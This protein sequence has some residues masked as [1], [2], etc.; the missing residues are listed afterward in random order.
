MD[1]RGFITALAALP[2][3]GLVGLG[4]MKR[5]MPPLTAAAMYQLMKDA[6]IY[7]TGVGRLDWKCQ[8]R[9]EVLVDRDIEKR[10]IAAIRAESRVMPLGR[11]GDGRDRHP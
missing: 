8:G 11:L 2:A 3:A 9:H 5:P 7:G 6:F 1:R 4:V 10:W